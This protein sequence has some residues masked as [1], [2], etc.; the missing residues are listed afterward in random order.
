[1]RVQ[2]GTGGC[3]R[4]AGMRGRGRGPVAVRGAVAVLAGVLGCLWGMPAAL[5]VDPP[6]APGI[7]SRQ[8]NAL[9]GPATA[10]QPVCTIK[11]PRL[12]GVSGMVATPTGFVVV[13]DQAVSA[14]AVQLFYLDLSCSVVDT[15]THNQRPRDP[16]DLALAP[17]GSIWIADIGDNNGDRATVALWQVPAD[18]GPATLYRLTYPDGPHDAEAIL[19]D[20]ANQPLIITKTAANAGIYRPAGDLIAGTAAG[21]PMEK[22]GEFIPQDTRTSNPFWII[23]EVMVTGAANAPDG[24]RVVIRTY[25][26]AYEFD[27]VGGDVVKAITEGKPRITP[28]P[29]EPQ[30]ES[31]GYSPDGVYFY[32]ASD[33]NSNRTILRYSPFIPAVAP[34]TAAPAAAARSGTLTSSGLV[35]VVVLCGVVGAGLAIAG[36]VGIT[37]ARRRSVG[38]A[39]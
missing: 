24:S 30:G 7:H 9:L 18:R 23:G 31:I 35:T 36:V 27:V 32:T 26:D 17:D 37:R 12:I 21:V 5:A 33:T 38:T 14:P 39:S 20:R 10:G 25:S 2:S 4:L 13:N 19:F 11:D 34:T 28:L 29:D 1:M 6:P 8:P 16:E 3:A 22:V 15:Y